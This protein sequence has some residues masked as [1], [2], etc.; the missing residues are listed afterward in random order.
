VQDFFRS[1]LFEGE[2]S[3]FDE[4]GIPTHN[5]D[6]TELSKRQLNKLQKKRSTHEKRLGDP[7]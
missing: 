3:A 7:S 4:K 1:S 2:F 5:A 6:G